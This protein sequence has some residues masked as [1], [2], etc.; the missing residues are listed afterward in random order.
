MNYNLRI[1]ICLLFLLSFICVRALSYNEYNID[2]IVYKMI[3]FASKEVCVTFD[4]DLTL[5]DPNTG[6]YV[7]K[8]Y[9]GDV[10][11][12]PTVQINGETYTVTE[13][14]DYAFQDSKNLTSVTLPETIVKL[15]SAAFYGNPGL[16]SM[17]LPSSVKEIGIECFRECPNLASINFPEGL[18]TIYFDAFTHDWALT[19]L[20]LPSSLKYLDSFAF[21]DCT[22]VK[23]VILADSDIP[24][25]QIRSTSSS[26]KDIFDKMSVD[27]AYIGRNITGS[28]VKIDTK[29]LVLGNAIA[30]ISADNFNPATLE[31]ITIPAS[32]K[33]VRKEAFKDATALKDVVIEDG[34]TPIYLQRT[35]YTSTNGSSTSYQYLYCFQN[36]ALENVYIGREFNPEY[37]N[38]VEVDYDAKGLGFAYTKTLKTVTIGPKVNKLYEY[39]FLRCE[40]LQ[41]VDYSKAPITYIGDGCFSDCVELA[42]AVLPST[43]KQINYRAFDSCFKLKSIIIPNGVKTIGE[44]AFSSS[45]AEEVFIPGSVETIEKWAFTYNKSLKV[46]TLCEG[47]KTICEHAF[48]SCYELEELTIPGSVTRIKA[49]AF[50]MLSSLKKLKFSD[51]TEELFVDYDTYGTGTQPKAMP[52]LSQSTKVLEE[53][54]IG[55]VFPHSYKSGNYYMYPTY[56]TLL[57]SP[58]N[59]N[60]FNELHKVT[61]GPTIDMTNKGLLS[62]FEKV[63]KVIC[64]GT[65]PVPIYES[66]TLSTYTQSQIKVYVPIG[67]V[68]KYISYNW[69]GFASV[70]ENV[71]PTRI[72]LSQTSANMLIGETI[73]LAATVYPTNAADKE[74][75]WQSSN[76]S[77]VTVYESGNVTAVGAGNATI[78][79]WVTEYENLFATCNITVKP[80]VTSITLSETEVELNTGEFVTLEATVKP[81][82]AANK[83]LIW[84]SSDES[85]AKVYDG[86]VVGIAD[87]EATIYVIAEGNP[88]ISAS[89]KVVVRTHVTKIILSENNVTLKEREFKEITATVLPDDATNS[90]ILWSSSDASVASAQNGLILAHK[91]GTAVIRVD[92]TDGS[93][94]FAECN[95]VVTDYDGIYDVTADGFSICTEPFVATVHGI[96]E[97]TII[98]LYDIYGKI[99][100]VGNGPSVEV[101]QSGVYILVVNDRTFNIKL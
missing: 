37:N 50:S 13:I 49:D 40:N 11:I 88:D 86:N 17:I 57:N 48:S 33:T 62:A 55:R 65:N 82:D 38:N 26:G 15:G 53:I 78:T 72:T 10:V 73:Q 67:Y 34:D 51:G 4:S 70:Q 76:E 19:E 43:L 89:C 29:E 92:S 22:G 54:Y 71:K 23:R 68:D 30:A 8:T 1:K 32:V 31:K 14:A 91:S 24:L 42:N 2:G 61:F 75:T 97:D 60:D 39:S 21:C 44:S 66:G 85:V 95:V 94:V 69:T 87:G 56:N 47:I 27:Y 99:L 79:V 59:Y 35:V 96:K 18:E 52:I 80:S 46:L 64:L 16:T 5:K 63:K 3:T 25:E 6:R 12:P 58:Y 98:R 20:V 45:G 100:Y 28:T 77:V 74:V 84:S 41:T 101:N 7:G 93:G 81:D 36:T 9:S 83:K 90:E